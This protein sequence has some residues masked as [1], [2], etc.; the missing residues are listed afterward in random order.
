MSLVDLSPFRPRERAALRPPED[1]TV[2]QWA[3][4]YRVLDGGAE[5]GPFRNDRTPYLVG[6]MN[7]FSDAWIRSI[8][9][10]K[11]VQSGGTEALKN[12]L[13]YAIDQDPADAI[14]AIPR[15]EDIGHFQTRRF[16][17][18]I[19]A[20]DKLKEHTTGNRSDE[21]R[22]EH[23]FDR[24]AVY[25]R[26]STSKADLASDPCRYVFG[27]EL[28][29]W[30]KWTEDEGD[31]VRL[32]SDRTTTFW[33]A[34][35]VLVSTPSTKWGH[36]HRAWLSSDRREFWV[37]CP[38]CGKFQILQLDRIRVPAAER[39]PKR[40]AAE[41][42][43]WYD[44][45]GCSK[46]IAD[47]SQVRGDMIANGQWV[48]D[49]ATI[50]KAGLQRGA[51]QVSAAGFHVSMMIT[52][53]KTWSE[54][55]ARF[56]E[57]KNDPP[58][59]QVFTNQWLGEIFEEKAQ[60]TTVVQ[61]ASLALNYKRGTVPDGAVCLTA[62]VDVQLD[63][64][65]VT[66]RAWGFDME[67]WLVWF[68]RVETWAGVF[69][70][71]RQ[72]WPSSGALGD[73]FVRLANVDSG[74]RTWEVYEESAMNADVA[75]PVKGGNRATGL[76]YST[77]RIHKN[78]RTGATL[79]GMVRWEVNTQFFKDK[80]NA[81]QR[82]PIG[83]PGGWHLHKNPHPEYLEQLAAEQKVITRDKRTGNVSW[84]WRPKYGGAANHA[85]DVEVY[86]LAAA[87]ML[88]VWTLRRDAPKAKEKKV[89]KRRRRK[90]ERLEPKI[91][92]RPRGAAS[93]FEGLR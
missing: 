81:L 49:G 15:R 34:K 70:I 38:H 45:R 69:K 80:L 64:F 48:P 58:E 12:M 6:I 21:K 66:V 68:G 17:P 16:A 52:P 40:I 47:E 77:H 86:A 26:A 53:W 61:L 33:N 87:H 84:L 1:M 25:F 82:T 20:C 55:V 28:D 93:W 78:P 43:A 7:A 54:I 59:L 46:K 90:S 41:R 36:I 29:K 18:M 63:H 72:P 9:I 91:E 23:I 19:A 31:P 71:I 11:S 2:S 44:C 62:G 92:I 89:Q 74:Y 5:P 83:D 85:M 76:P 42:L 57:V 35:E 88:E 10:K 24:M 50:T 37:P 56:F 8:A 22:K 60:E 65:W 3:E 4:R 79:P 39:D 32:L 14:F 73:S 75:R 27:D 30:N 67:S 51:R 13:G